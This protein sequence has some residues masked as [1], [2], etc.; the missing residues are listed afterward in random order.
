MIWHVHIESKMKRKK[1]KFRKSELEYGEP[2][3]MTEEWSPKKY[4][5]RPKT[6]SERKRKNWKG[7][8][9]KFEGKDIPI[10]SMLIER[11]WIR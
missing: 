10:A 6:L 7:K 3:G 4:S 2:R 9:L 5:H 11:Y 8:L 1:L